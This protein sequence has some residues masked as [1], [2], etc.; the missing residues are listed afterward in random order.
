MNNLAKYLIVGLGN[1]GPRFKHTPHNVGFEAIDLLREVLDLPLWQE[2]K[3]LRSLISQNHE[4]AITL[5]KP[6]TCMNNSGLAVKKIL[7]NRI[8]NIIIIHDDLAL[9]IGTIRIGVNKSSGG[10]KGLESIL[11]SLG[12]HEFIRIRIGIK[13]KMGQT[14][15]A[16]IFVTKKLNLPKAEQGLLEQTIKKAAVATVSLLTHPLPWVQNEFNKK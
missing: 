12:H 4:Q 13:P 6:Q 14:E 3:L 8:K 16:E 10:H 2:E 15:P 1:P 5:L 9:P 7:K 11:A